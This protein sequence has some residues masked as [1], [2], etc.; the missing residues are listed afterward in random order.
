VIV[1]SCLFTE[2]LAIGNTKCLV[3]LE[4]AEDSSGRV[5]HGQSIKHLSRWFRVTVKSCS[6]TRGAQ[7]FSGLQHRSVL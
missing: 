7:C 6:P 1:T 4:M 3:R 5:H 2:V